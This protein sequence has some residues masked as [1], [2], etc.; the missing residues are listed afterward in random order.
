MDK[1]DTSKPLRARGAIISHNVLNFY[2][3]LLGSEK[4]K[5]KGKKGKVGKGG[6]K[7]LEREGLSGEKEKGKG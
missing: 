2:P 4:G 6:E 1:G 3:I 7:M 5:G